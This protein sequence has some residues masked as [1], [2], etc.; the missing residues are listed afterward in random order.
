MKAGLRS[1]GDAQAEGLMHGFKPRERLYEWKYEGREEADNAQYVR[2]DEKACG[3]PGAAYEHCNAQNYPLRRRGPVSSGCKNSEALHNAPAY[4][5]D[6][7]V[8]KTA[9]FMATSPQG[10]KNALT[11]NRSITQNINK[12]EVIIAQNTPSHIAYLQAALAL[13]RAAF[14]HAGVA[15]TA[16]RVLCKHRVRGSNPRSGSMVRKADKY[17]L[18]R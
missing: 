18:P 11:F 8:A 12:A 13:P 1:G 7:Q 14:S 9:K 3:Q 10:H 4:R 15:Q 2:T 16:E 17:G 5:R 6:G